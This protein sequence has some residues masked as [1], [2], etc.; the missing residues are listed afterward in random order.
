[1]NTKLACGVLIICLTAIFL[2][3]KHIDKDHK[4]EQ[5]IEDVLYLPSGNIVKRL[6][7][8]FD[9][10]LADIYWLRSVQYFGRQ[11]LGEDQEIDWSRLSSVRYDL[12][13]PLLDI[14][15]TLDPQYLAAYRFGG[16]ILINHDYKQAV[17]ILHKGIAHNPDNWRLYQVL[18]TIHW[19]KREY[20]AASETFLKG[21]EINGAPAWMKVMGGV[22]LSQGGQRTTACQLYQALYEDAKAS[23][24]S[25]ISAQMERQLKQLYALDE[26]DYLNELVRRYKTATGNCPSSLKSLAPTLRQKSNVM[27]ACGQPVNI[28]LNDA[29]EPLTPFGEA[30]TYDVKECKVNTP[31][32]IPEP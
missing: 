14:T 12:L 2:L 15:T 17:Q 32:Y 24:D 31:F 1:M 10:V 25:L 9:G 3:Q 8:G 20:Q 11:M 27:G 26:I 6:S 21:A 18:A 19:Q 4:P 5:A 30:Y 28:A 13:Y 22:M 23:Q 29:G 7:C 16:V